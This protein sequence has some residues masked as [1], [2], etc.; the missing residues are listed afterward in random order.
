MPLPP[1]LDARLLRASQRPLRRPV[2]IT[3]VAEQPSVLQP[4]PTTPL[5]LTPP[6]RSIAVGDT[7][8]IQIRRDWRICKVTHLDLAAGRARV[9]LPPNATSSL[10]VELHRLRAPGLPYV[11]A[12]GE[13]AKRPASPEV[14]FKVSALRPSVGQVSLRFELGGPGVD[15][16]ETP[17]PAILKARSGHY[18]KKSHLSSR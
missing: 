10:E 3:L 14:H 18:S 4:S 5:I 2:F 15:E 1:R 9:V 7:V 11:G 6:P 12:T 13:A 17:Y 8:Q 16:L